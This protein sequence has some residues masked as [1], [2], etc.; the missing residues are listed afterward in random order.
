MRNTL[1][2]LLCAMCC[3]MMFNNY[4]YSIDKTSD[5]ELINKVERQIRHNV[6]PSN[7]DIERYKTLVSKERW[8]YFFGDEDEL[9][10]NKLS[11]QDNDI[12]SEI[13]E[14]D[15]DYSKMRNPFWDGK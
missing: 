8:S 6:M 1:K 9:N 14:E 10:D 15:I 11:L 5:E 4:G 3:T 13:K 7:D 12:D 2:F